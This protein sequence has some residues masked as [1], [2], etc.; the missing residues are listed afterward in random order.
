M[1]LM[2]LKTLLLNSLQF[3]FNVKTRVQSLKH[4]GET[5]LNQIMFILGCKMLTFYLMTKLKLKIASH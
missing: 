1:K 2:L 4:L 5:K 3:Y